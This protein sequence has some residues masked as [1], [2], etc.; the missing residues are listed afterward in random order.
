MPKDRITIVDVAEAAGVSRQTVSRAMNAMSDIAPETRRRVLEVSDRLGYRPSRFASNLARQ[1]HHAVGLVLATLRNPYYADLAADVI[2]EMARR[3]WQTTL[4]SADVTRGVDVELELV[5]RLATQVDAIV[6]YF[7]NDVAALVQAARG[8]PIVMLERADVAPGAYSVALDL[9][10][11]VAALVAGLRERGARC[12]AM[13]DSSTASTPSVP[14]P[15]REGFEAAVADRHA[16]IVAVPETIQGAGDGFERLLL[17]HPNVDAVVAFNDLMAMGAIQRA[18]AQ[19]LRVPDDVRVVG[20]DGL[21]LGAVA[22]PALS[23]LSIDRAGIAAA[24]ADIVTAAVEDTGTPPTSRVV[25]PTLLWRD[26]A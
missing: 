20:I 26:S 6:G 25:I 21:A 17:E 13:I 2:D 14:S 11:G 1:K 24:V 12:I 4:T 19:G 23:T 22:F 10:S 9:R 8:V 15:R 5:R 7:H 16:P 18:H 3:G